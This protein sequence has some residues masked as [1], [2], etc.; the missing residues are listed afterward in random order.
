MTVSEPLPGMPT[1]A[2]AGTLDSLIAD[3]R[4][5]Q[6]EATA[7]ARVL[8]PGPVYQGVSKTIRRLTAAG[9][10]AD[11]EQII[12]PV[13]HAGTIATLRAV[14]R[15]IDRATGHNLTGWHA[16]GRDLAPLLEQYRQLIQSVAGDTGA[17]AFADWL[18]DEDAPREESADAR[19]ASGAHPPI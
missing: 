10:Y 18:N 17:D 4:R 13:E 3:A 7:T 8:G 2:D 1:D 5:R 9:K 16:N 15:S 6:L 12:D 14:A 19:R 11:L